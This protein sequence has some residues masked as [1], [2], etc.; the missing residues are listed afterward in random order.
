MRVMKGMFKLDD[1][2]AVALSGCHSLGGA[3]PDSSGFNWNWQANPYTFDNGYFWNLADLVYTQDNEAIN[4]TARYEFVHRASPYVNPTMMLN[5]DMSLL[6][7]MDADLDSSGRFTGSINCYQ[8]GHPTPV[9]KD[10]PGFVQQCDDAPTA[11]Y[12]REYANSLQAFYR[13]FPAAW[14]GM[15]SNGYYD[16]YGHSTLKTVGLAHE[17]CSN[18]V[19]YGG[20]CVPGFQGTGACCYG[21]SCTNNRCME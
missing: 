7:Y 16:E 15:V 9:A 21:Y 14:W 3:D 2:H 13:D 10:V 12:V 18:C 11:Q 4:T 1:R 5:T 17:S 19:P 8:Q 20:Y 6:K